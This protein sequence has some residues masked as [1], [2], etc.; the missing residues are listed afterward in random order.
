MSL[1][2][3][4]VGAGGH[5][6][7]VADALLASGA[8]VLGFTDRDPKRH[9]GSN[10][11]LPVLGDDTVLDRHT[12][13]TLALANGIGG[14]GART[15]DALRR[16]VHGALSGRG[17]RFVGVRHPSAVVS[18]FARLGDAVQ[19]HAG[20]IVQ[21]GAEVGE[22]CIVNTGAVIE[23]DAQVGP[24][25]HV[26]PGALLCGNVSIGAR[27]HIGAGAIV[28][29]GVRLADDTLVG[30]GAVVVED[31]PAGCLLVGVPARPMERS[32]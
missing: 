25:C 17:W 29:Q 13:Q 5:A 7:V 20:S 28:R 22:G 2:V 27:C 4:I 18:P 19:L 8:R 24:W 12:P 26:A 1:P 32:K 10:C 6:T 31:C 21:P 14:V 30:A 23:H 11:G 3:I 9:G 16:A 15:G